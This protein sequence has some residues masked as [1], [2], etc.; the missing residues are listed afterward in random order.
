MLTRGGDGRVRDE[1][2]AHGRP[3]GQAPAKSRHPSKRMPEELKKLA[4]RLYEHRHK[5][6]IVERLKTEAVGQFRQHQCHQN[7]DVWVRA[8]E[9]WSVVRGWLVF[10]YTHPLFF[11]EIPRP[12]F[13][14]T[15]H[16]VVQDP[17]GKLWDVTPMLAS[18]PY[19]FFPHPGTAEEIEELVDR[20]SDV[21]HYTDEGR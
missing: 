13:R 20:I 2:G 6:V 21:C 8:N 10:D 18:Q 12:Y 1:L 4:I 11:P 15:A 19:P 7:A 5:A 9:G 14:F 17:A 16:S 3:D